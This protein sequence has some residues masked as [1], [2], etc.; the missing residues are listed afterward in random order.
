L[1]FH[2]QQREKEREEEEEG[3]TGRNFKFGNVLYYLR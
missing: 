1:V 2:F 3:K